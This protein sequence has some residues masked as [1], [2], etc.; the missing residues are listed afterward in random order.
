M[1]EICEIVLTSEILYNILIGY[2]LVD[3]K[4]IDKTFKKVPKN[5]TKI[6]KLLPLKVNDI[7]SKGKLMWIELSDSDDDVY[8]TTGFGLEGKWSFE[9][10]KYSKMS[11]EFEKKNETK[12]LW[13]NDIF[14]YGNITFYTEKKDFTKK[15]NNLGMDWMKSNYDAK[16]IWD[17]IKSIQKTKYKD[18]MIVELLMNQKKLGAGLGNYLTPEILYRAKIKPSRK[19]KNITQDDTKILTKTIQKVLK[20]CYHNNTNKYLVFL[21]KNLNKHTD[22]IK[23]KFLVYRRKEDDM[24]NPVTA[25]KLIKGRTTYW[26][27][28]VQK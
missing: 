22:N 26:V 5:L 23:W 8:M 4:V 17:K 10:E 24:G 28:E 1:P 6:Q 3:I 14:S 18:K 21:Q 15:I 27:K 12:I 20:L 13:W 2:K 7:N 9:K 25:S 19:I 11:F 16:I